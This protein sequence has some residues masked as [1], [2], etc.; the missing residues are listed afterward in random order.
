MIESLTLKAPFW[1]CRGIPRIAPKKYIY[2]LP[3]PVA[4]L[5]PFKSDNFD[6]PAVYIYIG[7]F[8]SN[9]SLNQQDHFANQK[10]CLAFSS[11]PVPQQVLEI[12]SYKRSWIGVISPLLLLASPRLSNSMTRTIRQVFSSPSPP[13]ST[14]DLAELPSPQARCHRP[15][16]SQRFVQSSRRQV[17]PSRCRSQ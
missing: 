2:S 13:N 8:C 5:S 6:N 11:S 17:R 9:I 7:P 14:N 1:L 16:T 12:T 4:L 15:R 10:S 3:F